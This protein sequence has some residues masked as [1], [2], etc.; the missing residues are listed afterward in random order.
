MAVLPKTI[1]RFNEIP[2]KISAKFFTDIKR[3]VLN[4]IRKTNIPG[5]AKQS[6]KIKELQ[7]SS[8]SLTSNFTTE[9]QY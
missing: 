7:E 2:I 6:Y 9:L 1:Y 4:L 5:K 3:T 8:Q